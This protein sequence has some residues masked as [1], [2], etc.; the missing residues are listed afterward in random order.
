MKTI[1]EDLTHCIFC[2]YLIKYKFCVG[3]ANKRGHVILHDIITYT[4]KNFI[5]PRKKQ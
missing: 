4:C 5:K 3:H 2:R 1:D